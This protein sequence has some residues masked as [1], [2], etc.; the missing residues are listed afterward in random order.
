MKKLSSLEVN[1]DVCT[2]TIKNYVT[3]QNICTAS[4]NQ[5]KHIHISPFK[6]VFWCLLRL[7]F[8]DFT[9]LISDIT[10]FL[11]WRLYFLS[12][13][14]CNVV[15]TSPQERGATLTGVAMKNLDNMLRF[16]SCISIL[17]FFF[18]FIQ[19]KI[20]C[21]SC[22]VPSLFSVDLLS[23]HSWYI[24]NVFHPLY[25]IKSCLNRIFLG[26][27]S[28]ITWLSNSCPNPF[29]L[30]MLCIWFLAP[31]E[32]LSIKVSLWA[33]SVCLLWLTS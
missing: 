18:L 29:I 8:C 20:T 5:T 26:D 21:P 2:W 17:P 7:Y 22:P 15:R 12:M 9:N 10:Q 33:F 24:D 31:G 19:S 13:R 3:P 23:V 1:D 4:L 6:V 28:F 25:F 11:G 27:P 30:S 32:T 14:S 16:H